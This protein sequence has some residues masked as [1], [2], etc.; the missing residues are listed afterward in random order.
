[1][2]GSTF[3]TVTQK[4][5]KLSEVIPGGYENN[6]TWTDP[7]TGKGCKGFILCQILTA[8][9]KVATDKAGNAMEYYWYHTWNKA[10]GKWADA[11]YWQQETDDDDY[12]VGEDIEVEL[13]PG[14]GLWIKVTK[15]WNEGMKFNCAGG[16]MMK[17]GTVPL[18]NG[19]TPVVVPL[20]ANVSL[21]QVIPG[22]YENN[23]TWTD[24]STGKGCKGFILCQF[25]T[26]GGK[27][28]TDTYGDA[29][30]YYWYHTWN[31]ATGKWA[32]AGYWQQETDD[33][34]YVIGEDREVTVPMGY[35]LWIKVT[36]NFNEG[37]LVTGPGL[38]DVAED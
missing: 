24:P 16:A 26:A 4:T 23:P 21:A 22:G 12:V 11:G 19:A 20:S 38:E 31:K 18:R 10:T 14:Q 13:D 6:P 33:D 5:T 1:M 35:G 17:A 7:S 34:D 27:V 30:E 15:N 36:K 37:M 29:M 3:F 9:G 2:A 8:G 28:D 25:L 32:D